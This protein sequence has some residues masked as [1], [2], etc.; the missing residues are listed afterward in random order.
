MKITIADKQM[1]EIWELERL[2]YGENPE[3]VVKY[4]LARELDDLRRAGVLKESKD[5]VT[6]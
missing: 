5:A 3:N 6:K 4:L 2:G 1:D